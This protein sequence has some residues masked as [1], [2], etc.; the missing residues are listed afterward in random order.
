MQRPR[1][2]SAL[3]TVEQVRRLDRVAIDDL[4]IPGFV[5]MQ[6]AAEAAMAMLERRWPHARRLDVLAGIG[7]NGGDAFLLAG[8]ARARGMDVRVI[9][10]GDASRGDD[11]A[12][13]RGGWIGQGGE[14]VDTRVIDACAADVVVDGLFGTGLARALEG[15]AARIVE[16]LGRQV[17]PIL[18]L[19]VPSG[20]DADTGTALGPVVRAQATISFVGWKRG[21]FTAAGRD[22]CGALEL[23]TLGIPES[24]HGGVDADARLLGARHMARRA[25]DVNKGSFGHVLAIGG[26]H[27]MGGAV[28]LAAEAALRV[29]AGLVSVATRAANVQAIHAA[30]AELMVHAVDGP[31]SI[32]AALARANALALGPGLG[33]GAWGHALWDAALRA[34][35]PAVIDADA[36]NL[37]ARHRL[38]LPPV[39]VLTPHPGE[40]ARLLDTDIASIQRDRFAAVRA[41]ARRWRGVVVLKGSGS[42]VGD[43]AGRVAV[44]P[45][46]NPGMASGGMGDVLTGVIAGLLAQG[47]DA[48]D[49]ACS[50]VVVHACAGDRAAGI[51]PRG[52]LASDLFP[53]LRELVNE[54][55]D[56]SEA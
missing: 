32:A 35:T 24:A 19:D 21:L 53:F 43:A 37:L 15:E 4:A 36:L 5:L 27:G 42:L 14:I 22:A 17:A 26:D 10:L 33:Q 38:D 20:L 45:F 29:G 1:S 25:N 48:W 16:S 28:R 3:Y 12:R 40:A 52:L 9:A 50:G 31:Q 6:R 39:A 13:A 49:A 47:L 18:A 46:G 2:S 41:L 54:V 51:A 11:A 30:R 34:G 44:C 55:G 23:A 7:N 56:E 8:L